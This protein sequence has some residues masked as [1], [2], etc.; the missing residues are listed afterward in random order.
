VTT[1]SDI[2]HALGLGVDVLKFFPA[3]ASG[4]V[5]MIKALSGPYAHKGVQFMPTGG[6][7]P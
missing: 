6:V 7:H 2:E 4:G 1:P 5:T 3:E